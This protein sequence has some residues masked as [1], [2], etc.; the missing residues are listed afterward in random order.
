MNK[1]P[2]LINI[3]L[4]CGFANAKPKCEQEYQLSGQFSS[5]ALTEYKNT[6]TILFLV[7][8]FGNNNNFLLKLN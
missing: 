7:T 2:F 6:D 4:S 5:F 3:F 1:L 8:P